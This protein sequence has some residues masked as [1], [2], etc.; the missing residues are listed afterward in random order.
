MIEQ[1]ISHF[2]NWTIMHTDYRVLKT[3]ER[4]L[5]SVACTS[6]GRPNKLLCVNH[7]RKC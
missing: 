2:K 4:Y 7:W 1:V 5:S 3:F 6:T